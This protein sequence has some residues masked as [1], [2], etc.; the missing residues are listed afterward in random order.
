[1]YISEFTLFFFFIVW[2]FWPSRSDKQHA[3]LMRATLDP[4]GY[5]QGIKNIEEGIRLRKEFRDKQLAINL[6][7]IE[8]NA[9][10]VLAFFE[11]KGHKNISVWNHGK[12][13]KEIKKYINNNNYYTIK[14]VVP[15]LEQLT[16]NEGMCCNCDKKQHE[17]MCCKCHGENHEDSCT[18]Y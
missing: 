9:K 8:E 11:G 15:Y 16:P 7:I 6:P 10:A 12:V 18:A 2:C 5:K 4:E 13:N 14:S 1:M 17:G 3:E